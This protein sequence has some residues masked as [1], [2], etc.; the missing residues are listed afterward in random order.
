MTIS[1]FRTC[2]ATDT[3]AFAGHVFQ[4]LRDMHAVTSADNSKL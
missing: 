1:S 2:A 3:T 4:A